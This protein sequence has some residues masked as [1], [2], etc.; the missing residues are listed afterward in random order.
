MHRVTPWEWSKLP[1]SEQHL[2]DL[3]RAAWR[4]A[5][6]RMRENTAKAAQVLGDIL[7]NA[8]AK[9]QGGIAAARGVRARS[10]V[11]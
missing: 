11:G 4:S 1:D 8:D 6:D 2:N 9:P 3:R 7:S 10:G 5:R